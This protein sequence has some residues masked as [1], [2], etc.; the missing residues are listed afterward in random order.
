VH[1]I[2][3]ILRLLSAGM[4]W[5]VLLVSSLAVSGGFLL[6]DPALEWYVGLS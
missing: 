1:F 6:F 3:R 2:H 4:W 5:L